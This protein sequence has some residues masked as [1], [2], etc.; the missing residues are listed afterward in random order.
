MLQP[1]KLE[2]KLKES[3]PIK[4]RMEV[5]TTKDIAAY[6]DNFQYLRYIK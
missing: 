6:K 2:R 3:K 5:I 1:I 4:E